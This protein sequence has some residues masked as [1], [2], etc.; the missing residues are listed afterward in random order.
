MI[1]YEMMAAAHDAKGIHIHQNFYEFC[2]WL[3]VLENMGAQTGV[4]IGTYRFG[5]AQMALEM[6]PRLKRLVTVDIDDVTSL[7]PGVLGRY[8]GRLSFV[9]GDSRRFATRA[10]ITAELPP[11]WDFL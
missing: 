3:N 6:L 2:E 7:N 10:K 1:T 4:E 8:P 9:Q 5:T 11:P